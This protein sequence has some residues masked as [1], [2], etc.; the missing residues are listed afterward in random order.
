MKIELHIFT[1]CHASA[2][3]TKIIRECRQSFIDTFG[4]LPTTVW[5]DP[6]PGRSKLRKYR[7][8]LEKNFK[9][10]NITASLSDGYIQA[11]QQS[12]TDYL[13]M[14]EGDWIFNKKYIKSNLAEILLMMFT[15]KIYHMRFNKRENIIKSWDRQ[16]VEKHSEIFTYCITNNLSNNPHIIERKKYLEFIRKRYI[17]RMP[18]SHGIEHELLKQPDTWGAIYGPLNYP[19]TITHLDGKKRK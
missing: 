18:R 19:A 4:E 10:V 14:L 3:S 2:P 1:N 16:L 8:N 11:I 12:R 5:C 7:H 15:E 13:F 17:R 6:N 9:K